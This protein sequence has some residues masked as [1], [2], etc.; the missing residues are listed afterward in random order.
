MIYWIA[1]TI[2]TLVNA[3]GVSINL[4]MLPGNWLMVLSLCVFLLVAGQPDGGPDWSTLLVV[5]LMASVGE[6]L[7]AFTGSVKAA[8][9]GASRR[10]M[11]LSFILSIGGSVA[12]TF[13]IPIPVIGTALG[14]VLGAAVDAF[15]E[16]GW[17]K[18]GRH[19]H[20]T[21]FP[22][23][24]PDD[25]SHD[26]TVRQA[27]SR[28]CNLHLSAHQSLAVSTARPSPEHRFACSTSPG[29]LR[30]GEVDAPHAQF[31][32]HPPGRRPSGGVEQRSKFGEGTTR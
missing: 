5:I 13:L 14:A 11:L 3:V 6:V 18:P 20:R 19:R 2:L 15:R 1:A 24:P 10:A 16:R 8:R 32:M 25:R 23:R 31:P 21:A 4:L 28:C 22:D 7:E 12:G 26:R 27:G 29:R 9:L 30:L 17:E